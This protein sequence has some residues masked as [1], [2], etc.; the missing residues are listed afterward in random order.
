MVT[1]KTKQA[2]WI[3]GLGS[4]IDQAY[5]I[6]SNELHQ[7]FFLPEV[8]TG[9]YIG[10]K[11]LFIFVVSMFVLDMKIKEINKMALIIGA[12]AAYLFS[13]LLTFMFP[14]AYSTVMHMFHAI[15]IFAAA[16]ITFRN[17]LGET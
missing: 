13:I 10:L 12:V 4:G 7:L 3:A 2:L 15:A 16:Q 8:E 17:K 14:G 9:Y 5:H 1:T 11:F 6:L